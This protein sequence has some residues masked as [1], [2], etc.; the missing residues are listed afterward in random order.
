MTEHLVNFWEGFGYWNVANGIAEGSRFE[1]SAAEAAALILPFQLLV[2]FLSARTSLYNLT[3]F[4]FKVRATA[5]NIHI[6]LLTLSRNF[7]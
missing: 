7:H 2:M 5:S 6:H 1:K 3:H 4:V